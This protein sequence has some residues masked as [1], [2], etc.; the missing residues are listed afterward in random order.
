MVCVQSPRSKVISIRSWALD[1]G[2]WTA[3]PWFLLGE[4]LRCRAAGLFLVA[5]LARRRQRLA[6]GGF[7]VLGP[8]LA[9][10]GRRRGPLGRF[11]GL[12]ARL[13]RRL[14]L[15]FHGGGRGAGFGPG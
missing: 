14:G 10:L 8:Q 3:L 4:A 5:L 2:H 12:F 11:C 9:G 6:L 7:L 1:V 15:G 13:A